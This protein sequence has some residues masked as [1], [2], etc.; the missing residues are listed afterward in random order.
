MPTIQSRGEVPVPVIYRDWYEW[1]A[2]RRS[3]DD[4]PAAPRMQCAHCWGQRMV[5][6]LARNGEGLVPCACD[7]CGGTGLGPG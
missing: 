2:E 5:L 6:H 7:A 4:A 1:R 3:G